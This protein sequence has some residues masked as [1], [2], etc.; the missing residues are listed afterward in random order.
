MKHKW[1]TDDGLPVEGTTAHAFLSDIPNRPRWELVEPV[2]FGWDGYSVRLKANDIFYRYPLEPRGEYD[3]SA[4]YR[5]GLIQNGMAYLLR[6]GGGT[7]SIFA[8]REWFQGRTLSGE[9]RPY[10]YTLIA[11]YTAEVKPGAYLDR[12]H[13]WAYAYAGV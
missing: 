12:I 11:R 5:V 8:D 13:R 10:G 3:E 9:P 1:T 6:W 2:Q 4:T 7:E